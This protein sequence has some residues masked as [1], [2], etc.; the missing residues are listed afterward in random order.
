MLRVYPVEHGCAVDLRSVQLGEVMLP[1]SR[2]S[3]LTNPACI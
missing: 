2:I 3:R 1:V